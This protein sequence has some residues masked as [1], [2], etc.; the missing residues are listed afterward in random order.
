MV[1][2]SDLAQTR[3][4]LHYLKVTLVGGASNRGGLGS[5]VTV[6]AGP[7]AYH[8]AHDGKSGYLSQ[9]AYPLYFGLGDAEAVDRIEVRWPSGRAQ[10]VPGPIRANSLIEVREP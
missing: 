1:L 5:V 8:R 10:V 9:S 6:R 3:R 7:H 4:D 2:V